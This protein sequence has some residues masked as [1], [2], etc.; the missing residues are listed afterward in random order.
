MQS[1]T[2][3]SGIGF[4]PQLLGPS[5]AVIVVS[6]FAAISAHFAKW[7]VNADAG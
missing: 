3:L 5:L 6:L 1:R 7:I 4:T 2:L